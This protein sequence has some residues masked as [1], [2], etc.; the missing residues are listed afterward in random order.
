MLRGVKANCSDKV[1]TTTA[2]NFEVTGGFAGALLEDVAGPFQTTPGAPDAYQAEE[3]GKE[4]MSM[5]VSG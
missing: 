1:A 3:L 5:K 4:T 2:L